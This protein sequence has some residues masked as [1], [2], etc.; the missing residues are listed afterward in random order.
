M[1]IIKSKQEIALMREAGK[2]TSYI[3][4]EL[5]NIIE[6]YTNALTLIDN[7][8]H[9]CVEKPR[10]NIAEYILKYNECVLII[11]DSLMILISLESKKALVN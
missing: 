5:K 6:L 8:D 10:G 11:C 4:N 2:V 3:L 9:Q 1:I 7:Y